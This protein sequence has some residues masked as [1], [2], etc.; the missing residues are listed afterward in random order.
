MDAGDRLRERQAGYRNTSEASDWL[1][2]NWARLKELF[3]NVRLRDFVFEPIKGVFALDRD[4]DR[5]AILQAITMVAVANAVMAGLPGKMGIGVVVSMALEGWMAYTIANRVGIVLK[6]PGDV[7]K[8]FGLLAAIGGTVLYSFR[9]LLGVAFSLFSIIPGVNPMIF[10]ELLVTDLVGVL[11]WVGFEEAR[12]K[13]S[14]T[15]PTRAITRIGQ[16]TKGLAKFQWSILRDNLNPASLMQ[17]GRRLRA[18]LMGEIPN[19][20]PVLRG[21]IVTAAMM[22]YLLAGRGAELEGPMGREFIGAIRDRYPDL[23]NASVAEIAEHMRGYGPEEMTGVISLVKGKLFERLVTLH[24]NQ[25][26]DEWRAVMHDDESFPGSDITLTNQETGEAI[27]ISLKATDS[28]S[29]VEAAL[30]RYPDT[31]ILTTEEVGQFFE[32]DARVSADA[33]GN[34]E[35]TQVT[36]KNF[37]RL[38]DELGH[39]D[40]AGGAA[41]GVAAGASIGLWPFVVAY[42]RGRISQDQLERACVRVF[43][44]SGVALAS[45]LAYAALLGPLF[46]WYLLARGVM[47][48]TRAANKSE[49]RTGVRRLVWAPA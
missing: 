4:D 26:G 49:A 18:W 42:M 25:D 34:D 10:A 27:E 48:I 41:A 36:E 1:E 31:P 38:L 23:E 37:D 13:G 3:T 2:R 7:W 16:E 20:R 19:D 47:G 21:D 8:Y 28:P 24:E 35:L 46:A 30:L 9:A 39:A 29:Y 14:F 40:V 43:G 33:L 15:I 17:T 45:R 44:D 12:L 22:G 32:G 11:F 5:G 6:K